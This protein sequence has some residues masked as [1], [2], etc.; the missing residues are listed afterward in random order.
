VQIR[1][2]LLKTFV[3]ICQLS[4]SNKWGEE[5][6]LLG[7]MAK[8]TISQS[9]RLKTLRAYMWSFRPGNEYGGGV[10]GLVAEK[11]KHLLQLPG[12]SDSLK[13]V[14][15]NLLEQGGFDEAVQGCDGV[16]HTASPYFTKN[17]TDPQVGPSVCLSTVVCCCQVKPQFSMPWS[18]AH[19]SRIHLIFVVLDEISVYSWILQLDLQCPANCC[20]MIVMVNIKNK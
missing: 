4:I 12:A 17:V 9:C 11:S 7:I 13:L 15:A 3:K 16:F 8:C 18:S 2:I 20:I 14:A 1:L 5:K 10:G 6:T 19:I